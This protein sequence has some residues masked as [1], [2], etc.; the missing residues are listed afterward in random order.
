MQ[1]FQY[2]SCLAAIKVLMIVSWIMCSLVIYRTIDSVD[3][4]IEALDLSV[5][6]SNLV[7]RRYLFR[8][9]PGAIYHVLFR[10]PILR[11]FGYNPLCFGQL[12]HEKRESSLYNRCNSETYMLYFNIQRHYSYG[13]EY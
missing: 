4:R 6:V 12:R 3:T 2:C 8:D 5:Y 11:K 7:G 1:C 9:V 13:F 10:E